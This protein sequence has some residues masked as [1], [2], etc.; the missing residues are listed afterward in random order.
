MLRLHDVQIW[1]FDLARS[2]PPLRGGRRIDFPKG[3]H[4][5]PPAFFILRFGTRH[6]GYVDLGDLKSLLCLLEPLGAILDG[7]ELS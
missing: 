7:L 4:R 3:D 2:A 6:L 5:C 1:A